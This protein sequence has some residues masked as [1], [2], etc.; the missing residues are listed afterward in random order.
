MKQQFLVER[1]ATAFLC[2]QSRGGQLI[3][4]ILFILIII[5]TRHDATRHGSTRRSVYA[6]TFA[7]TDSNYLFPAHVSHV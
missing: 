6:A 4:S 1:K 3:H 2:L 7:I 5:Q